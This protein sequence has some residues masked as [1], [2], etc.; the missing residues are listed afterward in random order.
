MVNRRR[1]LAAFASSGAILVSGCTLFQDIEDVQIIN[2]TNEEQTYTITITREATDNVVLNET[3]EIGPSEVVRHQ[4]P[5]HQHGTYRISF[6]TDTGLTG[7]YTWEFD[8]EYVALVIRILDS[9]ISF[10]K[11]VS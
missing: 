8:D 4:N 11:L 5:I 9:G 7:E 6:E 3:T 10:E 2:N 1:F